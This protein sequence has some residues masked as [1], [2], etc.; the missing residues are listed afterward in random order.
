MVSLGQPSDSIPAANRDIVRTSHTQTGCGGAC[1][2]V[3]A[4]SSAAFTLIPIASGPCERGVP[5]ATA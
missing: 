5:P 4:P 1:A 3:N 2:L